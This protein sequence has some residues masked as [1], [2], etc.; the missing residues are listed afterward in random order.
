MR[1]AAY[2]A[3]NSPCA[4]FVAGPATV[5]GQTSFCGGAL[6]ARRPAAAAPLATP[7]PARIQ[8][9]A[10][11][12]IARK[13]AKVEY[14]KARLEESQFVFQ[15]ALSGLSVSQVSELKRSL[16]EGS[17]CGTV[18]NTLMKRAIEGTEWS[19]VGDLCKDSTVWFFVK[20]DIKGTVDAYK[21]F[22]KEHK[23]D[24]LLGGCMQGTIYDVNG[25]KAIAELPTMDELHTQIACLIKAV[26]TK[27]ARTVKAVPTKLGRAIN[28][29]VAD[30]E[31][32]DAPAATEE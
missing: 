11:A 26:P 1:G 5:V 7:M 6:C 15:A 16:P 27:L 13:A 32:A 4:G 30:P 20:T 3:M 24:E 23:R 9:A 8:M 10:P 22:A 31:K 17:T 28:M 2:K 21:K 18:K 14:A 29:A 25:V 19:V 12:V